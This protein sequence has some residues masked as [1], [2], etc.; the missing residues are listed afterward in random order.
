[1]SR[2]ATVNHHVHASERQAYHIDAGGVAGKIIPPEHDLTEVQLTDVRRDGGVSFEHDSVG[3]LTAPSTVS[4]F[5]QD[6]AWQDAYDHELTTLLKREAGT[7]EVIIF[8]HT[9][10]IDD[11]KAKRK[12]AR[13]V[14]SDY[15]P[16]GAQGRLIDILGEAKAA[17]WSSGYYGFINVWRPVG[18][19]INSAPLGFVRPSSVSDKDWL[20]LDLIYPDRRGHIMGLVG[21][22]N[23]EWVYQSRMT[24]DEVAMFNIYDNRGRPSVAHS[25]LDMIEDPTIT[26]VRRS[27]ESRTLVRY[28][29]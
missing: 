19:P 17:E 23:H 27:I 11:P 5:D 8:D 10:R 20:L 26:T 3:F 28:G 6:R 16:E 22:P 2:T 14:H 13:N 12:P 1:M 4:A 7:T 24:P 29:E 18:H 9:V 25:A 15:S 21:N